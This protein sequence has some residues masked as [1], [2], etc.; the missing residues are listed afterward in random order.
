[1]VVQITSH[2]GVKAVY[3]FASPFGDSGWS[4]FAAPR[5][6]LGRGVVSGLVP[7]SGV[8]DWYNLPVFQVT[9]GQTA[10]DFNAG[11]GRAR[12]QGR[13]AIFMFHSIMPT[14]T[15]WLAGVDIA[16][17]TASLAHAKSLGDLWVDT[18]T[19]VGAYARATDV[20]G[21][22][23]TANTWAW[24]LPNHFPPGKILRVTVD[25]ERLS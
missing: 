6:L 12:S 15:N 7:A 25:G 8:S 2:L 5:V 1:M 23:P 13:W 21:H 19:A 9:A 4:A 18:F 10:A 22:R 20:R 14:T 11:I 17:I 16:G 3:G 24:I